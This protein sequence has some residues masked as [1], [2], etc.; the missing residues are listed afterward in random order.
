MSASP[1]GRS[2][3]PFC[4]IACVAKRVSFSPSLEMRKRKGDQILEKRR[5]RPGETLWKH[6]MFPYQE[7]VRLDLFAHTSHKSPQL[8]E[9]LVGN[10]RSVTLRVS[11]V[12]IWI[13][14]ML[15]TMLFPKSLDMFIG[16]E[17]RV[18][19]QVLP[20]VFF[21]SNRPKD[22]QVVALWK[23]G[24]REIHHQVAHRDSILTQCF[25]IV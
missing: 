18:D 9:S 21:F 10:P 6:I 20:T 23:H 8:C 2:E 19:S 13:H 7:T 17:L 5:I 12:L 22:P 25:Q 4:S 15:P 1:A 3:S 11:R 14:A 16:F 24:S